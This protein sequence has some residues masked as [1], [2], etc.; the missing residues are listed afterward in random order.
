MRCLPICEGWTR[1]AGSDQSRARYEEDVAKYRQT[2]LSA[3]R[4]V[5]DGLSSLRILGEQ[6]QVQDAAVKSASMAAQLSQIQYR[7][8]SVSY[9]DVID[10]DRMVLQQR[11]V[12]VQLTACA[13]MLR[14]TLFGQ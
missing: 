12:A 8:G 4:D 10:A 1:Q 6:S 14:W 5:E 3:F 7:E 11:R 2:V 9:L 13:P